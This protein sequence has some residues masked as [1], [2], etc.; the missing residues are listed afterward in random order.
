MHSVE[1]YCRRRTT[2]QLEFL[3]RSYFEGDDDYPLNV[4]WIICAELAGRE[5]PPTDAG[6]IYRRYSELFTP[7]G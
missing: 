5:N 3:L 2:E 4:I 1:G 6:V 7:E